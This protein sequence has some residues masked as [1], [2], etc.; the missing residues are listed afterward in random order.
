MELNLK[1][2]EVV[3]ESLVKTKKLVALRNIIYT[4]HISQALANAQASSELMMHYST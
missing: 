3:T 2:T 4:N 1:Q